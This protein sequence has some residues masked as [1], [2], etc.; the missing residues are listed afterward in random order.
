MFRVLSSLNTQFTQLASQNQNFLILYLLLIR[1][2]DNT[3]SSLHLDDPSMSSHRLTPT[4][5][6]TAHIKADIS[7]GHFIQVL[8]HYPIDGQPPIVEILDMQKLLADDPEQQELNEYP[9]PLIKG[10]THKKT[11]IEYC[12]TK[13][14]R[15]MN[16]PSFNDRD[17]YILMWELLI[18]LLRQNGVSLLEHPVNIYAIRI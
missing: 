15:A 16:G 4:K 3:D 14:K 18:L 9:G 2:L 5:F 13:I 6:S 7:S 12:E 10:V 1:L 17:S 11:L 8:P